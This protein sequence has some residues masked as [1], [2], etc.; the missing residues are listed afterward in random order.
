MFA[1]ICQESLKL[2]LN[3]LIGWMVRLR[4]QTSHFMHG[5]W[6]C[7]PART[8]SISGLKS[9]VLKLPFLT[10]NDGGKWSRFFYFEIHQ[11]P[12]EFTL[13]KTE[14]LYTKNAGA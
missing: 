10:K 7:T 9:R 13:A 14:L 2:D 8:L 5:Y 11:A 3:E 12:S 6:L 1:P 4:N